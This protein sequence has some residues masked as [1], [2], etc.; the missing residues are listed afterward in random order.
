MEKL[1]KEDRVGLVIHALRVMPA[2]A[3]SEI[4]WENQ[5][6]DERVSKAKSYVLLGL[7]LFVCVILVTPMLLA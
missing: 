5:F 3:A 1:S 6:K 4:L 7:L 2:P